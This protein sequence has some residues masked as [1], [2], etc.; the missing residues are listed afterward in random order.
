MSKQFWFLF[1]MVVLLS[2]VFLSVGGCTGLFSGKKN[3]KTPLENLLPDPEDI[4]PTLVGDCTYFGH[5]RA[6]AVHGFGLVVGL[7]GTGGEDRKT[8][9]Y[10]QVYADMSRM[11]VPNIRATLASPQTAVVEVIGYMR[12]G[13]Q[14]G[15]RFDVQIRLPRE[16]ETKSLRGGR[17]METKLTEMA[18]IDGRII[19][20]DTRAIVQGPIMVDDPLATETSNPTGLKTGTILGGA[21]TKEPRALSLV[22]KE[23][24]SPFWNDQIAK[25]INTRF[26]HAS[27]RQKDVATAKTDSLIILAIHPSYAN[28]VHRYIRVVQS[29]VFLE[30]EAQRLQRIERLQGELLNPETAQR[31]AFQLEAIG[32]STIGVL[33]Q[34]L[35][36]PDKEVRF[37]AATALAYLGDSTSAKMLSDI[38]RSEPAFRVYALNALSVMKNDL[39]AETYLQEL[40]HVPSAETRYGAFRALKN[41]NPLDQ[42]IRGEILGDRFGQF[43]Y[44][45]ITSKA[46]PMV[47]VTTKKYPEI[48]LF[49]MDIFLKQP[50]ALN[51]GPTIYVNGQSPEGVAVTRIVT[52]GVDER[53]TVSNRLD[54]IIRAVVDMD[55]TYPDVVQ[56]LREADMMKVLSC[57]L[58]IDRLPEPD[59]IYRRQGADE[60]EE[61]SAEEEKP[62][63]F[64]ERWNPKNIFAPNPGEKTSD[65]TGTVNTP[66]RD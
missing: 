14:I 62:K 50:F 18:N 52:S 13:I 12:S 6:I 61:V 23:K 10:D 5:Y 11:G 20:G 3:Q 46:A 47:H 43:S 7:P 32:K 22:Q 63:S 16:S 25:A 27:G 39:E 51:A 26:P 38:A 36:S 40:L 55:G 42:T 21:I 53:R 41:R 48:V 58:E 33:Q 8:E 34:A 15:D 45:G 30:N 56:M 2:V 54:D 4:K 49:G 65:F 60:T 57:R 29:I 9:H 64:W 59:R 28:D 37:H 24:K 31:A 35:Q 44:H 1:L 19:G 66:I 17:L